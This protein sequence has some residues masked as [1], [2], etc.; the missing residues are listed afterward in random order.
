MV[1]YINN[2]LV[3]STY[4]ASNEWLALYTIN[5]AQHGALY[6]L[7]SGAV[8]SAL[9]LIFTFEK[10]ILTTSFM[11]LSLLAES[12]GLDGGLGGGTIVPTESGVGGRAGGDT[13]KTK[14]IF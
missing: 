1:H 3:K 10:D 14:V 5:I 7:C 8:L 4:V 12:F 13:G 9:L 2:K 6:G 11:P